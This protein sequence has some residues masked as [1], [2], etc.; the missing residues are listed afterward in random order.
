MS[1]YVIF[2]PCTDYHQSLE[3]G[4][5]ICYHHL[6]VVLTS[7]GVVCRILSEN[8]K[9][10]F[11]SLEYRPRT[12]GVGPRTPGRS[13][14]S[15]VVCDYGPVDFWLGGHGDGLRHI[16]PGP[17]APGQSFPDCDDGDR[18]VDPG[19]LTEWV[20]CVGGDN[21]G[22]ALWISGLLV[23]PT[24][25]EGV[26]S[27]WCQRCLLTSDSVIPLVSVT[28]TTNVHFIVCF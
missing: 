20:L 10:K 26:V 2:T 1:L 13:D 24:T 16:G 19:I 23:R 6:V 5:I 17:Y 4:Q 28:S 25:G 14:R 9:L 8:Y 27:E 18:G 21:H 7:F 3:Q 12:R 11:F 22:G 15:V